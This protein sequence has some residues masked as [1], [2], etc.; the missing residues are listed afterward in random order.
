MF[1]PFSSVFSS[2]LSSFSLQ[3]VVSRWILDYDD[4][5]SLGDE[6]MRKA[7]STPA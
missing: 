4:G 6:C 1:H 5:E 2:V 7:S 3:V